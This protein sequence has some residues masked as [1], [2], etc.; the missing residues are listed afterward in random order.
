MMKIGIAGVGG[1]GS[2][3][4]LNLVR[5]G[6]MQLKLVDFDRV[7]E[8]NLNRQFY[9]AD[10]IGQF[11]VDALRINLSRI[12]PG[13]NLETLILCIDRQNCAELFF[14]CDLIVEGLDRQ[15]DKKML[16]ETFARN[17]TVVS[18]SGIAGS[19]LAGIGSR[20]IGN[21]RIIG[22]FTTDCDQAPLFSHKVTTVANYMSEF[23]LG[24]PGVFGD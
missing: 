20:K 9:F 3:V 18:A 17:K 19:D 14:D 16:I 8:S 1:I 13:V 4:A 7:E 21:S 22:D 2:N 5:S 15:G 10:Q 12:N 24:Q 6:V 11:K 23:I